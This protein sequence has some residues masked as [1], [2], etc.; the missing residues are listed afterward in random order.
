MNILGICG[1]LRKASFN[2][3]LLKASARCV[4]ES[5][6]TLTTF[7][8]SGIPLYNADIDGEK[9]PERVASLIEAIKNS[10]GIIIASP[11]Y[12]YSLSGVLKNAIDWASRPAFKSVLAGKPCL[13]LSASMSPTGGARGQAHLRNILA[14]TLTPVYRAPDYLLPSARD[15]FD[16]DG[17]LI[18][19][20]AS[21][22][23]VRQIKG[24]MKWAKTENSAS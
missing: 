14:G 5:G 2:R 20:Q 17:Q 13:I 21:E 15:A 4:E 3:L 23:L 9:K 11:E 12:N 18:N 7:D 16:S 6:S 1:S 24:F 8:L 10:D 19:D 22:R